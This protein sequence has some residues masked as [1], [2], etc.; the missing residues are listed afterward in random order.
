M[1]CQTH[2]IHLVDLSLYYQNFVKS[3]FI[4]KA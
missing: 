2:P 1:V 3:S 4:L